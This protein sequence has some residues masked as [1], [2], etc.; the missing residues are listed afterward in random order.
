MKVSNIKLHD[1]LIIFNRPK[2]IYIPLISGN[3]TNITPLVKKGEYVYKGSIV[4]KRKGSFRIPIHSSV[5]G[6]VLDF[7]VMPCFNGDKVNCIVIENDFKE[8]IK[9]DVSIKNINEYTKQ[10]FIENITEN[11]IVG[12]SSGLPTYIKYSGKIK[13]LIVD[14]V[15]IEPY[16]NCDYFIAKEKCEEILEV[17]D[18]ILEINKIDK[19]VI[20]ISKK[21]IKLKEIFDNYIGTYLKI[22]TKIVS[23]N[24]QM[25]FERTLVRKITGEEYNKVPFEKGIVVNNISTI[26]AMY[27][28]L[29]Y[30]KPLIERVITFSNGI[31]TYNV[32]VKIGTPIKD[33]LKL[34]KF[35]NNKII[36]GGVI[37]GNIV[38]QES[39]ISSNQNSILVKKIEEDIPN[40]CINC[41]KCVNICPSKLSPV[42]IMNSKNCNKLHPERCIKCGLCS[43]ICPSKINLKEIIESKR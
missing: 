30:N 24:Y 23:N 1:E 15:E 40:K 37:T 22:K 32:L 18:A 41:G 13:T 28:S 29:K 43:Y 33:I 20:A 25:G 2:K 14:V 3:D 8:N 27:E 35:D 34:L 36:S 9:K 10:E 19:A 11:G 5:S 42:L 17:I 7:K 21:N 31:D 12:L 4:A 6:T 16:S 26:Y 39:I 38:P